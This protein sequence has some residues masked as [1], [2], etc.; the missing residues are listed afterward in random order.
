MVRLFLQCPFFSVLIVM[1]DVLKP[2][3]DE[4]INKAKL[5][6][7]KIRYTQVSLIQ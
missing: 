1:T 6:H 7:K 3:L 5:L 2:S 4:A